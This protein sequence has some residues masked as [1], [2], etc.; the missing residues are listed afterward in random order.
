MPEIT[1]PEFNQQQYGD[2]IGKMN[3]HDARLFMIIGINP[4]G[5][6]M[7]IASD[8]LTQEELAIYLEGIAQGIRQQMISKN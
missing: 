3:E 4:S 8:A 6:K 5:F 7:V 1:T 2:W